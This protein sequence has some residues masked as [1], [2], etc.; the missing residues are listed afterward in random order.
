MS[1]ELSRVM[2]TTEIEFT[3]AELIVQKRGIEQQVSQ[4]EKQIGELEANDEKLPS[5]KDNLKDA[6]E[7]ITAIS[8]KIEDN[9]PLFMKG[10]SK[11]LGIPQELNVKVEEKPLI[12]N[13][14]DIFSNSPVTLESSS[15]DNNSSTV[16]IN[17]M[18]KLPK[19]P[20]FKRGDNFIR[21]TKR[22]KEHISLSGQLQ[23]TD[24][25]TYMLSHV[26]CESTWDRLHRL[27][28]STQE[29]CNVD[30]LIKRYTE[31]MFP[32]TQS[33]TIRTELMAQKQSS[34]ETVQEFCSRIEELASK[35]GYVSEIEKEQ[36]CLQVLIIGARDTSVKTKLYESQL[37][38]YGEA[39]KLAVNT[40][41][42]AEVAG[43]N[44][45]SFTSS[46]DQIF[47]L[48]QGQESHIDRPNNRNFE[49]RHT[50]FTQHRP[51]TQ[52]NGHRGSTN[53]HTPWTANVVSNRFRGGMSNY[54][55]GGNNVRSE[56]PNSSAPTNQR[57]HTSRTV[58]CWFC[59]RVGHYQRDCYQRNSARGMYRPFGD[60]FGRDR[61]HNP[62]IRTN[63]NASL[64]LRGAARM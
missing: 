1:T 17:R 9:F 15:S 36:S 49:Q 14:E 55:L 60:R 13:T 41:R 21:W 7:A 6:H 25:S 62:H 10:L 61:D 34:T 57:Y 30:L 12:H 37:T 29:K 33:W 48:N 56:R 22:F 44:S 11:P 52:Y 39:V 28:L 31:E 18:A 42:I 32:P 26:N 54:N 24:I 58:N 2:S 47:A 4:L 8:K 38:S 53:S 63:H 20:H 3:W 50:Q 59:G 43:G 40:E 35:A 16:H 23:G 51:Q 19:P 46:H 27:V 64:N 5:L 45:T